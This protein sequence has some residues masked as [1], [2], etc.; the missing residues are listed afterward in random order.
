MDSLDIGE[1]FDSGIMNDLKST[2]Q[3][4][5]LE[6]FLQGDLGLLRGLTLNDRLVL[7]G[8]RFENYACYFVYYF[9]ILFL[10]I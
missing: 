5:M 7:I 1:F 10:P 8:D 2:H 4:D 9:I 3:I 6:A